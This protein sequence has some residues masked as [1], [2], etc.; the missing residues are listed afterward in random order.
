MPSQ[1]DVFFSPKSV[2]VI[3]A[4]RTPGKMGYMILENLKTTFQGKIYPVNPNASEMFGMASFPSVLGIEEPI[5]LAIIAVKA[6]VVPKALE[7]C[8]KKKIKGAII[9][10]SGFAEA[11]NIAL[12]NIVKK[13]SEKILIL[14]PNCLGTVAGGR[15]NSLALSKE[16]FKLPPDGYISF[17][18]QSGSVGS[19]LLDRLAMEGV[20]ISKFISYGNAAGLDE[21]DLLDFLGKDVSTRAIVI[22]IE[23]IRD[24][25]RF[26]DA[27]KRITPTKPIIILKAGRTAD[28]AGAVMGH[29]GAAAGQGEV[30]SAAFRQAGCVEVRSLEDIFD[31]AKVLA[32]QPALKSNRIAVV[33]NGGG[34][35][36]LSA[37]AASSS[38]FSLPQFGKEIEKKLREAMPTHVSV[39][40][41]LDLTG[42]ANSE[43][44]RSAIEIAMKDKEIAGAVFIP[45]LQTTALDDSIVN[46]LQ[47]AKIFGK[48]FVV[49]A[50][51]S[52]YTFK[53]S[54]KLEAIG[55]PVYPTPE[56]AV[57]AL[58]ALWNY[59]KEKALVKAEVAA[60]KKVEP[61]KK[62]PAAK[63]KKRKR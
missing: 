17:I 21:T 6:E 58:S 31:Y 10:S 22:Y 23:S 13:Y 46:V 43:R 62:K 48:P 45:L 32:T 15:F 2:A 20:G 19:T 52:D 59:K 18:C 49:C 40:N 9:V 50:L 27:A 26:V 8:A 60:E 30:F 57:K 61:A 41:P 47:D 51:G 24:G 54:R 12:E 16:R 4:S 29:I 3:G 5:E 35:A 1:L 55:I 56:R 14:G 36:V 25:K 34:F 33:S 63:A 37:D 42:D 53:T 7:E 11:G 39:K 38:G 44:F 28:G